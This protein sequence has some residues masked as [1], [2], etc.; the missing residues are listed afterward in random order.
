MKVKE[1][2]ERLAKSGRY[3]EVT[4]IK[5]RAREDNGAPFYHAEYQTTPI[6]NVDEWLSPRY[7]NGRLL[8]SVVLNDKQMPIDWLSGSN[9]SDLVKCGRLRCLLV[10]SQEDFALLY[11]SKEQRES[12]EAYIEKK[13]AI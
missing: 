10:V 6:W 5:A 13:L 8:D 12:M 9:W 1:Y 11:K 3:S 4:F 7:N 2:L